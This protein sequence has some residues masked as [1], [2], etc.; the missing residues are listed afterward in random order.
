MAFSPVFELSPTRSPE[1]KAP[2]SGVTMGASQGG[3]FH[4]GSL[5][6]GLCPDC[7]SC[8]LGLLLLGDRDPFA[9]MKG[10]V[11]FPDVLVTFISR[12]KSLQGLLLGQAHS[13]AARQ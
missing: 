13:C 5:V 9:P 11:W 10:K 2:G 12:P 4:G 6:A 1:Q 8:P 7:A 3:L